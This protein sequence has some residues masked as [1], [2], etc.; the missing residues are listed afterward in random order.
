MARDG[1]APR[2]ELHATETSRERHWATR[3]PLSPA[4]VHMK[5]TIMSCSQPEGAW[6]VRHF[7][8]RR[9]AYPT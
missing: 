3:T 5:L 6:P 4:H 2:P 9:S 1:E 7:N 8:A